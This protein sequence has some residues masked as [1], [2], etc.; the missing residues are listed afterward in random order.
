MKNY[1]FFLPYF[2]LLLI[3]FTEPKCTA[4]QHHQKQRPDKVTVIL[5]IETSELEEDP[6]ASLCDDPV[7]P[8]GV[9]A[10]QAGEGRSH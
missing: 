6:R 7:A 8:A 9:L 2:I 10:A 4:G 3:T 5:L 1:D